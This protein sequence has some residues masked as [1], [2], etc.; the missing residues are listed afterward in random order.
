MQQ[1]PESRERERQSKSIPRFF[2]SQ[3]YMHG[4]TNSNFTQFALQKRKI[5]IGNRIEMQS[6]HDNSNILQPQSESVQHTIYE[7]KTKDATGNLEADVVT[8]NKIRSV[9]AISLLHA[10]KV[11]G[12]Q[13]EQLMK[14]PTNNFEIQSCITGGRVQ[15]C[16]LLNREC[17]QFNT[18]YS[19]YWS[20][21]E[22]RKW[23]LK[24]NNFSLQA[25]ER[26]FCKPAK[27][28]FLTSN[29]TGHSYIQK[30]LPEKSCRVNHYNYQSSNPIMSQSL[31]NESGGRMHSQLDI[32]GSSDTLRGTR[33]ESESFDSSNHEPGAEK[34]DNRNSCKEATGMSTN[35]SFKWL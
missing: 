4:Y 9:H 11:D 20:P 15:E 18:G 24:R 22:C 27:Q 10:V 34:R 14:L 5:G 28:L 19:H 2:L 1:N 13:T 26:T 23:E 32:R 33:E 21:P 3:L 17:S 7:A 29:K 35:K 12:Q 31:Q 16:E 8:R 6:Q 25:C 30:K